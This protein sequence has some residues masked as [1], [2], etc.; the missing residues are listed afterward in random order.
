MRMMIP[1]CC[2]VRTKGQQSWRNAGNGDKMRPQNESL[3][4]HHNDVMLVEKK[5]EII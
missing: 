4:R 1:P 5:V 2:G 3:P